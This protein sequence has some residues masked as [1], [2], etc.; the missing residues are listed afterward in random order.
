[1]SLKSNFAVLAKLGMCFPPFNLPK[2]TKELKVEKES[3]S[4]TK[5]GNGPLE[6]W[7]TVS[8]LC[9]CW[10]RTCFRPG[11]VMGV[12]IKGG[13]PLATPRP[14][15]VPSEVTMVTEKAGCRGGVL[16]FQ[17]LLEPF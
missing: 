17:H 1:M 12:R 6:G 8:N 3:P 15:P 10:W 16:R 14:H 2:D 11:T 7:L 4:A 9:G 13:R 5:L